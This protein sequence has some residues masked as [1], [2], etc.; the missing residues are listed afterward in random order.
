MDGPT[1]LSPARKHYFKP[2]YHT[3]IPLLL[4]RSALKASRSTMDTPAQQK[5][6]DL[7][8]ETERSPSMAEQH[9]KYEA[10]RKLDYSGAGEKT[11]P[12]EIALVKRLDWFIMVI[13]IPAV[14]RSEY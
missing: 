1:C 6:N 5:K 12:N 2:Y 10:T 13:Q 9:E 11:D 8:I 3:L 4:A 14:R 7:A